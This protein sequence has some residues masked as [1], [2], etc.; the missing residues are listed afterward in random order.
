MTFF[1][2]FFALAAGLPTT[3][4]LSAAAIFLAALL[5]I[6]LAV[7]L[8][9]HAS[10]LLRSCL[11]G[12][13]TFFTGTPLLVQFFIFY[14]LFP[15]IQNYGFALPLPIYSVLSSPWFVAILA[16]TLNSAAYTTQLFYGALKNAPP[17]FEEAC[18]TLGMNRVQ[19]L[20]VILPY[21]LKR[22][23]STYGNEIIFV[24]KGSAL[25]STITLMDITGYYNQLM[26]EYYDFTVLFAAALMYL[27]INLALSLIMRFVEYKSLKFERY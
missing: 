7:Y 19:T 24:V 3:L 22:A 2:Y 8:K 23:L 15:F 21:A 16:L 27:M 11:N 4:I 17:G 13:L 6:C 20:K 9:T 25:A 1:D 12:L 5:A 14:A 26:G 18:L 10:G